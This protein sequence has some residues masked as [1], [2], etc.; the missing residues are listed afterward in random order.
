MLVIE[1]PLLSCSEETLVDFCFEVIGHF[2]SQSMFI[3]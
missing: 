2:K 3:R 1:I